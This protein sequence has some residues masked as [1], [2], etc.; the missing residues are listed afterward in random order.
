[1]LEALQMAKPTLPLS[2]LTAPPFSTCLTLFLLLKM[3]GNI[4]ICLLAHAT[5]SPP[6]LRALPSP[7]NTPWGCC[8]G[9][10]RLRA[11]HSTPLN[12]HHWPL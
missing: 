4:F 5:L 1:M 7:L 10:A 11:P 2:L 12:T 8:K 3:T 6:S 9:R